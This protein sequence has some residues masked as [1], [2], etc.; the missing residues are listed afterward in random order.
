MGETVALVIGGDPAFMLAA[1]APLPDVIH[2]SYF[3][4]WLRDKPLDMM[5][6]PG[7][8]SEIPANAETV[9]AATVKEQTHKHTELDVISVW[10]KPGA[11]YV[12]VL[13]SEREYVRNAFAEIML[14]LLPFFCKDTNIRLAV[15]W[16][17]SVKP[18]NGYSIYLLQ[19]CL[20]PI[21][22]HSSLA[23]AAQTR[24]HNVT[25][26]ACIRRHQVTV[27]NRARQG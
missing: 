25:S 15:N 17:T 14:P 16:N 18:A 9:I 22:A 21:P 1:H 24:R 7:L 27:Q 11:I 4:S 26:S 12:Q 5:R 10:S 13:P 8:D 19:F 20:V 6:L 3:A 23:V 2:R